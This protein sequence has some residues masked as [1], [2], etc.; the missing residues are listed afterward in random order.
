MNEGGKEEVGRNALM[1]DRERADRRPGLG[2]PWSSHPVSWTFWVSQM[3]E[4]LRLAREAVFS[5]IFLRTAEVGLEGLG[6]HM[7]TACWV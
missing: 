3:S 6:H 1:E 5:S 7:S 4:V 2:F